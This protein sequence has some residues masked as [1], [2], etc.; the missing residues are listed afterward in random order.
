MTYEAGF[1][2]GERD[3]FLD[4][5]G[6][7]QEVRVSLPGREYRRGYVDGYTPRSATWSAAAATPR[8]APSYAEEA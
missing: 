6:R 5:R 8:V 2:H 7:A 1:A 3:A 4:R